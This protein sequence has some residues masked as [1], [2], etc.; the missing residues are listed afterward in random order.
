MDFSAW[1]FIGLMIIIGIAIFSIP[2]LL[3]FLL[4][5][6]LRTKGETKKKI[7]IAIF[8][9]TT[10]A[11]LLF[12]AYSIISRGGI[13]PEYDKEEFKQKIGG[14]LLC[15]SEYN[16]D[17]HNW[18]YNVSY[19]YKING[20]DS[21][22]KI[23]DGT[24]CNREWN[25]DE[26]LIQY[27]NWTILKTGGWFGYDKVIIGD[28]KL[29]KWTEYDF[30]AESIER[31]KLWIDSKTH[32][33]LNYCCSESFVDKIDNGQIQVHYKFR[34]SETLTKEYGVKKVIYKIDE[35]TGQPIMTAIQ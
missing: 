26:Q 7:G 25:K 5:R 4:Y 33:L 24:Y 21:A 13:G 35:L 18:Y 31:E 11:M 28:L 16:A 27:K 15:N 14:T 17:I 19:T 6:K 22:T 32:S 3:T 20:T 29:N 8:S 30:S 34:T 10:L 1:I 9:I 12:G 2:S 23:G